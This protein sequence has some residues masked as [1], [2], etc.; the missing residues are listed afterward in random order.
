MAI[1]AFGDTSAIAWVRSLTIEAFVEKRSSL[2]IP[3]LRG[4]PAGIITTYIK[5]Q[6]I[7]NSVS[8]L[9][10]LIIFNKFNKIETCVPLSASF[11]SSGPVYAF[12]FAGVSMCDRSAATPGVFTTSYNDNSVTRGDCFISNESGW[13]IPPLAPRIATLA[14]H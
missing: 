4:T 2:V 12:I 14:L 7:K 10:I 13:P 8:F 11:S 9:L 5:I 3:G 1:K 6:Q